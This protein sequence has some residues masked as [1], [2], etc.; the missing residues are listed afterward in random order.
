MCPKDLLRGT[1]AVTPDDADYASAFEAWDRQ[2]SVRTAPR[3]VVADGFSILQAFPAELT[4]L[5]RSEALATLAPEAAGHLKVQQLYR[6]L[7]FTAKLEHL[8]VNRTALRIAHGSLGL[9][10]PEPMVFD[11]YRISVDE[12]YHA[13]FSADLVRQVHRA[14]GVAP[15]LPERPVFLQRL[16]GLME[17]HP[18]RRALVELLFVIVSETLITGN[19]GDVGRADHVDAA[20]AQTMKD[21]ARDEGRHHAYFATLAQ[22]LWAQMSAGDRRFST[23]VLPDLIAAFTA[24]EVEA[25]RRDL[26][27]LGLRPGVVDDV[28]SEVF[29]EEAVR[30]SAR[31]SARRTID[32]FLRLGA[33]QYG[34]E[35]LTAH[36]D[37]RADVAV[38]T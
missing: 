25:S 37:A 32:L 27:A 21:H 8:V 2:A 36:A 24:P 16:T 20:V 19:L 38:A 13:L 30:A 5:L 7:D 34:D 35:R 33:A 18:E 14:S 17:A 1:G 12:A 11:A 28:L 23:A 9:A 26:E 15:E 4:P 31:G 10:L 29:S 6:F 3:R 22:H